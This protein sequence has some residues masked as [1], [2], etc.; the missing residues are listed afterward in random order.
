MSEVHVH[1][2][3]NKHG[4]GMEHRWNVSGTLP[5]VIAVRMGVDGTKVES[6]GIWWNERSSSTSRD[7]KIDFW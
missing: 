7:M 2:S 6:G 3:W 5:S 1:L 4:I